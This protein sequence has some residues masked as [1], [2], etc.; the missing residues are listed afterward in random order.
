[1]TAWTSRSPVSRGD[2]V[3]APKTRADPFHTELPII[4]IHGIGHAVAE[5]QQAIPRL[6]LDLATRIARVLETANWRA[7]DTWWGRFFHCAGGLTQ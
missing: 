6:K 4:S 7:G 5:Q 3:L 1:M 2:N